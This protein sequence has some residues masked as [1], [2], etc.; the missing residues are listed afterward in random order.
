MQTLMGFKD[1]VSFL[2][3]LPLLIIGFK[4]TP[5]CACTSAQLREV[6]SNAQRRFASEASAREV[7]DA[8][9]FEVLEDID[10]IGGRVSV[11]VSARV[12]SDVPASRAEEIL[13]RGGSSSG[14]HI[15]PHPNN[16]GRI[17]V[18][19]DDTYY[20]F[21]VD[22]TP[23][24]SRRYTLTEASG[25]R[26]R[27]L[28]EVYTVVTG[29]TAVAR[30]TRRAEVELAVLETARRHDLPAAA[31]GTSA[32]EAERL[33]TGDERLFQF[34]PPRDARRDRLPTNRHGSRSGFVDQ[35]GNVW[36]MGRGTRGES[37]EWDVQI[38]SSAPAWMTRP[39]VSRDGNHIN[40]S[41][42]GRITH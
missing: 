34:H 38:S 12:S 7:I 41:P 37:F 25:D 42:G 39:P 28:D 31:H 27:S 21:S 15:L 10:S 13:R 17:S 18:L 19:M 30:V 1:G 14:V 33:A 26:P 9:Q 11:G 22:R 6:A 40:V 29:R 8:R 36:V 24:G 23:D 16:Q 32:S 3:A 5:A 20:H 4:Q 35:W 2:L